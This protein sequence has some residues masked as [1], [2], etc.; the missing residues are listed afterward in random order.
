MSVSSKES[1]CLITVLHSRSELKLKFILMA[2][3]CRFFWVYHCIK[4]TDIFD[5]DVS[6]S[7]LIQKEEATSS[8]KM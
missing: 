6:S 3:H 8:S 5:D 7:G 2:T 4:T 1:H